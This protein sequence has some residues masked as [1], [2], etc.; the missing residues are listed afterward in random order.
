MCVLIEIFSDA[1]GGKKK[2]KEKKRKKKKGEKKKKKRRRNK[3]LNVSKLAHLLVLSKPHR[4]SERVKDDVTMNCSLNK[5][6]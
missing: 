1:K 2:K 6:T 4:G 3:G 5:S